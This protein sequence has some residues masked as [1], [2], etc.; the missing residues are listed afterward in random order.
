MSDS[1]IYATHLYQDEETKE[2]NRR[3]IFIYTG[4]D[5]KPTPIS[6]YTVIIDGEVVDS[7]VIPDLTLISHITS[8]GIADIK[9][10]DNCKG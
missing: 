2:V 3:Y 5:T 7:N 8:Y 4:E 10:K 9:L 1:G 6:G